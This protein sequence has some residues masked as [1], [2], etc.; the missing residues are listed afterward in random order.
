MLTNQFYSVIKP[1]FMSRGGWELTNHTTLDNVVNIAIQDIYSRNDWVFKNKSEEI[2]ES[3]EHMPWFKMWKTRYNIDRPI[4]I[5]DEN[6]NPLNPTYKV[7]KEENS[8]WEQWDCNI[9][10]NFI[11]TRDDIE[12]IQIDYI[13]DYTWFIYSE[14]KN[15]EL[16]IPNKFIPPLI[17]MIYDIASPI[18]YFEDDEIIPRYQIAQRQLTNLAEKDA[19]TADT[20][21]APGRWV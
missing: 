9:W 16:P 1:F 19:L 8:D 6:G 5:Y 15:K 12:S 7:I 11:I 20:S 13:I 4:N 17:N 21:F 10:Q 3:L 2:T 14:M 18:S